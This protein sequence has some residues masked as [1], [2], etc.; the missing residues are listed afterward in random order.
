MLWLQAG[1]SDLLDID[2]LDSEIYFRRDDL[3][4]YGMPIEFP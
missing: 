4:K 1:K 3:L 2:E